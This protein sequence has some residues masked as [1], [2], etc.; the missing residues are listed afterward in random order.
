[1]KL[2]LGKDYEGLI[3]FF[4]RMRPKRNKAI[5]DISGLITETEVNDLLKKSKEFVA[6]INNKLQKI[7]S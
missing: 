6:I 5:Y 7:L 1:M 4:D 3:G 2:A